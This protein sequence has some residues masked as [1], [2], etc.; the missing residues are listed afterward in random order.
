MKEV[1]RTVTLKENT[2]TLIGNDINPGDHAPNFTAI[3]NDLK[4]V[5]LEQF[6]GKTV[7]ILSVPSLDTPVC[8][9]EVRSFNKEA[10]SL[11]KNVQILTLSMDLP[12]AQGRWCGAAGVT[13]VQTLS[14]HKDASFGK[15]YGMLI[16]E[17]RLL[18]RC[19]FIIDKSGVVQYKQLVREISSEPD[20]ADAMNAI[21]KVVA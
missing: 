2:F 14:D 19:V 11:D 21:K 9:M 18:A 10:A 8:D 7:V 12:F 4:P 6:K 13:A 1:N 17:L 20:Y 5:S 15:A 16:N 3:A